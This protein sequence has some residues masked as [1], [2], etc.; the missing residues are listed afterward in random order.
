MT[1]SSEHTVVEANSEHHCI[2]VDVC[3]KITRHIGSTAS[4]TKHD[5]SY[6]LPQTAVMTNRGWWCWW[7]A[8]TPVAD[9]L[10]IIIVGGQQ[11][12]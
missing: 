5:L 8:E 9:R 1:T 3:R 10:M 6:Q 11:K 7:V 2:L 12:L 4:F